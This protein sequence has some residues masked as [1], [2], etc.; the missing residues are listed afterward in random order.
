MA[1]KKK[2]PLPGVKSAATLTVLEASKMTKQGRADIARWLV[3]LARQLE[4]DGYLYEDKFRARYLY[5]P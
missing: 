5:A 3:K 1:A 4:T 2:E